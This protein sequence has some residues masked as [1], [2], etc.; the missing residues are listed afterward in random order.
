MHILLTF[1]FEYFE[2]FKVA[3]IWGV[4]IKPQAEFYLFCT[5]F[6]TRAAWIYRRRVRI[7]LQPS[8]SIWI[9]IVWN[10]AENNFGQNWGTAN[11]PA[12]FHLDRPSDPPPFLSSLM[13][14]IASPPSPPLPTIVSSP[15]PHDPRPPRP[16]CIDAAL[17]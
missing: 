14:I 16:I 10:Y 11:F 6:L 17:H 1:T 4:R 15:S 8:P 9:Q 12:I 7:F 2:N 3:S 5:H 13:A